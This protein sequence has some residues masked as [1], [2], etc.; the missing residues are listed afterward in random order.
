ML[1]REFAEFL[2]EYKVI[3]LAVGV[4]M[5]SASTA[6]VN[7]FVK[8]IFMPLL[9]PLLGGGDWRAAAWQI[10]AVKIGYGAFLAEL[11]NFLILAA[12]VFLVVKKLLTAAK[13]VAQKTAGKLRR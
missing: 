2:R 4:V 6:L 12:V 3:S 1:L 8:E 9:N 11:L 7:A 13:R 10:G 5:G